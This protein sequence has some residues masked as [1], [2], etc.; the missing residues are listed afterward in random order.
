M[1]LVVPG[2]MPDFESYR[3]TLLNAEYGDH[4]ILGKT[5]HGIAPVTLPVKSLIEDAM[6][7]K[8]A[9][10]INSI[11]FGTRATP[12]THYIHADHGGG[13]FGMVWTLQVPDCDTGM[14]FWRHRLTGMDAFP[15][16]DPSS[17]TASDS[18]AKLFEYFDH[19]LKDEQKWKLK[20]IVRNVENQALFFRS[21]LWHSRWPR[22]LPIDDGK[23]R[24]VCVCFF[25]RLNA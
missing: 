10:G 25:S 18:S 11:R 7:F 13:E 6:G 3:D 22:E 9:I 16:H 12:L 5:Y 19:E 2:F 20:R 4:E 15:K 14:A 21:N 24:V 8:V 23:P 1:I 17:A